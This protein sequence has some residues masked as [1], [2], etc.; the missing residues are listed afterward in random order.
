[1]QFIASSPNGFTGRDGKYFYKKRISSFDIRVDGESYFRRF[2]VCDLY[3]S[4]E[5]VETKLMTY[6]LCGEPGWEVSGTLDS[7]VSSVF[8]FDAV[9]AVVGP[10]N[11][12]WRLKDL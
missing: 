8:Y 3:L 1:M 2:Y 7:V 4:E 12:T 10:Y 11:G 6:A 5:G 9:N